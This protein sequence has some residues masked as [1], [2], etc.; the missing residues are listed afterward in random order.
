MSD[1]LLRKKE[2][3]YSYTLHVFINIYWYFKLSIEN[4]SLNDSC[5]EVWNNLSSLLLIKIITLGKRHIYHV[6]LM[7][8]TFYNK[9][10]RKQ[11]SKKNKHMKLICYLNPHGSYHS[12]TCPWDQ[13]VP[14]K[15]F[16]SPD[17]SWGIQ[18]SNANFQLLPKIWERN[19]KFRGFLST[20]VPHV[21]AMTI[22][23]DSY[24]AHQKCCNVLGHDQN[25]IYMR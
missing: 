23:P 5:N 18:T 16:E 4:N 6:A 25:L 10:T 17:S 13:S 24:P 9:R 15:P 2:I 21:T 12:D 22:W 3:W 7:V 14:S 19:F 20:Y 8:Q 1:S 11:T